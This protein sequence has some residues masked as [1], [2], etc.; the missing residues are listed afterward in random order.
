MDVL[1]SMMKVWTCWPYGVKNWSKWHSD[2]LNSFFKKWISVSVHVT[3]QKPHHH[4]PDN[5]SLDGLQWANMGWSCYT[6][7]VLHQTSCSI[8]HENKN[9]TIHGFNLALVILLKTQKAQIVLG[10]L[11]VGKSYQRFPW[12]GAT[13]KRWARK[14]SPRWAWLF[15][16]KTSVHMCFCTHVHKL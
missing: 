16:Q 13:S 7:D 1:G 11:V 8:L 14:W 15:Y 10:F 5:D 3:N 12:G 6:G 9:Q 2:H 4:V